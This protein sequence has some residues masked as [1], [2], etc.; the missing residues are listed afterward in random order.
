MWAVPMYLRKGITNVRD[1]EHDQNK[2]WDVIYGSEDVEPASE[3][4]E[5]SDVKGKENIERHAQ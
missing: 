2:Q 4:Q 1:P 3:S 5:G